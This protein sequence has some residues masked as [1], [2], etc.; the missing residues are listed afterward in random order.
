MADPFLAPNSGTAVPNPVPGDL[1]S[2]KVQLQTW[3]NMADHTL[4]DIQILKTILKPWETTEMKTSGKQS[5]CE[6]DF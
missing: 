6:T 5:L 3:S 4:E 2:C 1:P